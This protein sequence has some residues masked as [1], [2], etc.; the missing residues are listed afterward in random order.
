MKIT[1]IE[2]RQKAFEKNFRGY[3][4][5]EVDAFLYSL[6]IAWQELVD[7]FD[8]KEKKIEKITKELQRIKKI[9]EALLKNV[10]IS[11]NT[12]EAIIKNAEIEAKK[13]IQ[14]KQ[15]DRLI[16]ELDDL[17]KILKNFNTELNKV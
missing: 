12:A 3:N 1:P 17:K 14:E 11:T 9:E 5:D 4:I 6:S 16:K 7:N 10:E 15:E 13:I 8:K 2:I